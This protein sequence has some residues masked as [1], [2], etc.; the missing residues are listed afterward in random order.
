MITPV[1]FVWVGF[2]LDSFRWNDWTLLGLL[3]R[4]WWISGLGFVLGRGVVLVGRDRMRE[5]TA[6]TSFCGV[7]ALK[8]RQTTSSDRR[9][10]GAECDRDNAQQLLSEHK[11]ICADVA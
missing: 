6:D 11:T 4:S 5:E 8:F 1:R 9:C 10:L 2:I 7:L 3:Q